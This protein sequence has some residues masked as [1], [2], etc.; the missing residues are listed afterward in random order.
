MEAVTIQKVSENNITVVNLNNRVRTI[1][2]AVD[3]SN[4]LE[5]NKEYIIS[6]EKKLFDKHRLKYI[7]SQIP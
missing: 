7:S 4:L 5:V 6:Y 1:I 2:L 3:I